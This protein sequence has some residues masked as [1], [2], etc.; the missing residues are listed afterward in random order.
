MNEVRSHLWEGLWEPF[1]VGAGRAGGY[2]QGLVFFF[3]Q[4]SLGG[5]HEGTNICSSLYH[6]CR[7]FSSCW[8]SVGLGRAISGIHTDPVWVACPDVISSGALWFHTG[9][10]ARE[11]KG[12]ADVRKGLPRSAFEGMRLGGFESM[13]MSVCAPPAWI[14]HP[15]CVHVSVC[16]CVVFVHV[17]RPTSLY[18]LQFRCN[19][20]WKTWDI[21]KCMN[22]NCKL[23]LP[24][25]ELNIKGIT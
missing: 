13:E 18:F 10:W 8:C 7:K 12:S 19:C 21:L 15:S 1:W 23:V 24:V 3:L 2:Q 14:L 11:P 5:E 6:C 17:L 22:V 25:L 4:E 9:H 16:V 20:I